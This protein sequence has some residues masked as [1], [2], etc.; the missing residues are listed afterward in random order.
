ME[1]KN[2]IDVATHAI[3]LDYKKPYTRHGKKYYKPYRN[4]FCTHPDDEH[5]CLLESKGYAIHG[6]VREHDGGYKTVI[7]YLTRDGLDWL[8]N[9][10]GIK[11][12]NQTK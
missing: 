3:G 11:I 5:W 10:L 12:Y 7:F 4:Y 6:T 1:L 9:T 2:C 8:E